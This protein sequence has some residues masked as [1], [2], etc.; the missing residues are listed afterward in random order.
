MLFNSF[1][2]LIFFP[3][4]A[5]VYFVLPVKAR[6]YWLLAA[7]LFF[8]GYWKASYLL[9]IV[10][11]GAVTYVAGLLLDKVR[12]AAPDSKQT[13]A[14]GKWIV[15]L[16]LAVVLGLLAYFKYFNFLAETINALIGSDVVPILDI[17]MPVGISYYTFQTVGYVIDVYRGTVPAQRNPL[18]YALF[19]TFFP[20]ILAGPI[21]R[22]KD[23]MPQLAEGKRFDF[24]AAHEGLVRIGWGFF[25][26]LVVAD[27]LGLFVNN[28]F[29]E[30]QE[31]GSWSLVLA[32]LLFQIQLYCDFSAYSNMAIGSAQV[33][34]IRLNRNFNAPF[35]ATSINDYWSR[36]HMTLSSWLGDYVFTPLVWSRWVNKLF[37][38]KKWEDHPPH[39]ALNYLIVFF[40]SGLWHGANWTFVIWGLLH[41]V[42]SILSHLTTKP[43]AK[44]IKKLK[45]NKKSRL[46][47]TLSRAYIYLIT[48]FALIFFKSGSVTDAVG[49]IGRMLS[50][51]GSSGDKT[52]FELGLDRPEWI[53]AVVAIVV[54]M[55]IDILN[56]KRDMLKTVTERPLVLRWALYL[57][58]IFAIVIFGIYG[59]LY[60]PAPFVYIQF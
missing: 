39:F 9:L 5:I 50:G 2:Y 20:Q 54:V 14:K 26:K 27:R 51:A 1:E 46:H 34:G 43:R 60:D 32:A 19:T 15:A 40:I 53:V 17:L 42:Y 29:A 28:M 52:F 45:I 13:P 59:P 44:L 49:F 41:G 23:L 37:F 48:S 31:Q 30:Y 16:A 57:I 58:L 3:L 8:Y 11:V 10:V 21:S 6:R 4:A 35:L 25:C 47:K 33:F 7:G 55:T 18:T 56:Q 22:A 36:W 12:Q 24:T 38:G